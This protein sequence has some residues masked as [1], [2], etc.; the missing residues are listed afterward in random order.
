MLIML[1]LLIFMGCGINVL[2]F[3]R[4]GGVLTCVRSGAKGVL[5][6]ANYRMMNHLWPNIKN[7]VLL[8]K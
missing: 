4:L 2:V 7:A 5:P 8:A 6:V 1:V 3:S